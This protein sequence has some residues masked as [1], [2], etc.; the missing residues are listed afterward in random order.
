MQSYHH[1]RKNGFTSASPTGREDAKA[2][3]AALGRHPATI[4]REL[5]RNKYRQCHMYTYHWA[6][7][8]VRYRK[9]RVNRH[10][11]RKVTEELA[12]LITQLLV[13]T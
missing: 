7:E 3:A 13:T 11:A 4:C 9:Q 10:K 12:S 1:L 5:K 8:I 2:L 6:L